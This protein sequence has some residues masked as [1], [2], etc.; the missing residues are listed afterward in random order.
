[1]QNFGSLSDPS[2]EA[3][4]IRRFYSV[5][6]PIKTNK[7][8]AVLI[9]REEKDENCRSIQQLAVLISVR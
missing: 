2:K 6:Q 8:Q 5:R 7:K 4:V 3:I 1:V 9:S